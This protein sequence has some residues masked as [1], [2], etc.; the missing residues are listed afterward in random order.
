MG[1]AADTARWA[2]VTGAFRTLG[3]FARMTGDPVG[4]ALSGPE[5]LVDPYPFYDDVRRRGRIARGRLVWPTADYALCREILRDNR[6]IKAE[7]GTEEAPLVFRLA[8]RRA[9]PKVAHP[10]LPPSMLSVNPPEHTRYRT[11]V[12]KAF[13]PR[14]IEQLR[15]R[16]HVVADELLTAAARNDHL[17]L[18][19][20]FAG[21][22]PV[23]IISEIL[24]I[25]ESDRAEFRRLGSSL[26]RMIDLDLGRRDY[27]DAMRAL[28]ELNEFFDRH[29]GRVRRDPGDD[30]LSQLVHVEVDGDRLS[31]YE[32]KATAI[33]LLVAGFETTVNLIGNGTMMLLGDDE[34]RGL[35]RDDETLWP[36]AVEEMLRFDP[37]V[38]YTGR[39]AA[40][41]TEVDGVAIPKGRMVAVLIG[42]ANNDPEVFPE[43][44]R[45]DV[46]RANARD[47]IAFSAGIHYCLG[48]ALAR[49]EGHVALQTLFTRYPDLEPLAAPVRRRTRLLR[50]YD[51]IPVRLHAPAVQASA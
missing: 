35:L 37:P 9:D 51:S 20:D 40:E 39:C 15:P 6:F 48:A 13:T 44:R 26:S 7:D 5:F 23:A 50:G 33:L 18:V 16:V 14:A 24:G 49:L 22:L 1:R 2:V 21:P 27:I 36:N 30:I 8:A 45:F 31:D 25:P 17:D 11:L 38:Q 42:G 32:L 29:I 3:T 34:Q 41:A 19:T 46:T 10:L 47:Q 12:S 43:P 4:T 28:R